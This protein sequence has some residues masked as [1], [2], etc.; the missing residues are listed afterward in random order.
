MRRATVSLALVVVLG[1]CTLHG[2]GDQSEEQRQ[3]PASNALHGSSEETVEPSVSIVF[4][5]EGPLPV[6]CAD[7]PGALE[8]PELS[9][10]VAEFPFADGVAVL[11]RQDQPQVTYFG[12]V[13][14]FTGG[15]GG[16]DGGGPGES[17][18]GDHRVDYSAAGYAIVI[19][20]DWE[21]DV[22]VGGRP[23]EMKQA[24][25]VRVGLV[26]GLFDRPPPVLLSSGE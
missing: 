15:G 20:E 17:W 14:C 2:V 10:V 24:G 7:H 23:V 6:A 19:V 3:P 9:E 5:S 21:S 8:L 26:K 25:E 12:V 11:Y 1:A 18:Q 22:E 13:E 16:F 4:P